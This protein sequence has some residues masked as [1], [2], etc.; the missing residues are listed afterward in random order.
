MAAVRHGVANGAIVFDGVTKAYDR[1][2]RHGWWRQ[3]IPAF[4]P[5]L[6]HP[7]RALDEVDLRIEPGEAVGLIGPNGAGKST[8]LKLLAGVIAATSGGVHL[9][10][11]L[12][13]M[14]ELGL[15]FHPE[16]TGWEN[17]TSSA[18]MLGVTPDELAEVS[19]DLA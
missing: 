18:A 13:S 1:A 16:L 5:V 8:A 7:I 11:R 3:A 10:G 15:G 9:G 14:I 19:D 6:R 2:A 12:G 4:E 17:L